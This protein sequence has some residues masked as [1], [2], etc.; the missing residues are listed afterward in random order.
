MQSM[1]TTLAAK[2]RSESKSLWP[3]RLAA[4]RRR[5]I[6]I[7]LCC[8][9][10]CCI[11][12][13]SATLVWAN[14]R[15]NSD[16]RP[17]IVI[18]F[19]DDHAVQAISAYGSKIN[20]TPNIDRLAKEGMLFEQSFCTNSVCGPSRACLLTGKHSHLNGFRRNGDRFDGKQFTFPQALQAAGYQTALFGKWH[21]A[22][23]PTGFDEWRV[24]PDQGNY[25]NPEFLLSDGTKRKFEGYC[26]DLIADQTLEWLQSRRDSQK[27]FLLMTQH[28]APHRNWSPPVRHFGRYPLGSVPEPTTFRDDYS[29]RSS[30]LKQSEM[31]IARHFYWGHD[32]K[33]HGDNL[34][35]DH[36]LSGLNNGEYNRMTEAQRQAWDAFYEPE[37][38]RMIQ[39]VKDGVWGAAEVLTWKFQRYMHDYLGTVAALDDAVGRLLDYLDSSGLAKN[40]LVI[41]S[42]DQGFY[43]GEHGWY[44]KRW[45]FE[46]SLR[47]P[48][49]VRFPEVVAAGS[50]SAALVQNIDYAPTLLEA[51]GVEVPTD[52][53]GNS[54]MPLLKNGGVAPADWRQVI[55]Y[56]YHENDSVHEVPVHDGIRTDRFKLMK[57][58]RNQEWQLFDLEKDPQELT[59]VHENPQYAEVFAAMKNQYQQVKQDNEVNSAIIPTTRGD[60][61]WWKQRQTKAIEVA[62]EKKAKLIFIGDSITQGWEQPGKD[63]FQ[64]YFGGVPTLNMG[65]SGDRTEHVLYRL[66]HTPWAECQPAAAVVMI[67]T[68][69]TG[70]S[71]QPAEQTLAG[72]ELIIEKLTKQAPKMKILLVGIL[73]RGEKADSPHRQ[74][75]QKINQMLAK[76]TWSE[77]VK[78]IDLDSIFIR[79]DGTIDK[80]IMPDFLHLSPAGYEIWAEQLAPHLREW[81]VIE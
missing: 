78:L 63:V 24:L 3:N 15:P 38:V 4:F 52:V 44:D 2:T 56:Q 32:L 54:L 27:P 8:L 40:T 14:D 1:Q 47:M 62:K 70:H 18:I 81:K 41:Y 58:A 39:A 31:S 50:R 35:P 33:L 6:A 46:E 9:G 79:D 25:Y 65:F 20:Q 23:T 42:S 13:L 59:S 28:K 61:E 34:F 16:T 71:M 36:F 80:A 67:G 76:K 74:L 30:L 68:N 12:G 51:A 17:N 66:E 73:P 29:G 48:L 26:T 22:S 11:G 49:I 43:L 69:N 55:Y 10:L 45:M 21:L 60:E 75:N 53:Q 5:L 64:K 57:F 7:G 77:Q 72:I 37:N 19:S